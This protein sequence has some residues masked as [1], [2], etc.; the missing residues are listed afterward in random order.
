MIKFLNNFVA[1]L[2]AALGTGDT[3]AKLLSGDWD[4]IEPLVPG[5]Y[6][7]AMLNNGESLEYVHITA[8]QD[9]PYITLLRAQ[10]GSAAISCDIGDTVSVVNTA[11]MYQDFTQGEFVSENTIE[12]IWWSLTGEVVET[13][14]TQTLEN[15]TLTSPKISSPGIN[16]DTA[17]SATSPEIDDAASKR[18]TQNTDTGTSSTSFKINLGANELEILSTLLTANRSFTLPDV[19]GLISVNALTA[20]NGE[21][22]IAY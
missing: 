1:Q 3:T 8:K 17:L 4:K 22:V 15:K 11:G 6:Y 2:Q 13:Q 5:E 16:G 20:Q 9:S 21:E 14:K 12:K 7:I 19:E 10:E 18:H